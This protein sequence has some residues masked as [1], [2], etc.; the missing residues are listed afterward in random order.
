M[1]KHPASQPERVKNQYS[2]PKHKRVKND[3]PMEK[4]I[5]RGALLEVSKTS[6]THREM[7]MIFVW[8]HFDRVKSV[9]KEPK[10]LN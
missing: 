5:V 6:Q 3:H 2:S 4:P 7:M 9:R 10:D 8:E 1:F